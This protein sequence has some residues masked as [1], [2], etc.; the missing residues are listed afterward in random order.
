MTIG[1]FTDNQ[2]PTAYLGHDFSGVSYIN[3]TSGR[4]VYDVDMEIIDAGNESEDGK[5]I[6][7]P[8]PHLG[9]SKPKKLNGGTFLPILLLI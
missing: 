7:I 9:R 3:L 8:Q 5:F 4:Y 6:Y 2:G 1:L